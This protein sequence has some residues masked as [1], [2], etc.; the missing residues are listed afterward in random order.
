[1]TG[2]STKMGITIMNSTRIRW[3]EVGLAL[4]AALN[5]SPSW[6]G[7]CYYLGIHTRLEAWR[8]GESPSKS[9]QTMASKKRELCKQMR[10]RDANCYESPA[11]RVSDHRSGTPDKL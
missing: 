1:M 4:K 2:F 5:G 10:P 8:R 7:S 6:R 3:L 11:E 9:T